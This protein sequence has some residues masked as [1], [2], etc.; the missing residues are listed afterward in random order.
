MGRNP[1]ELLEVVLVNST[2]VYARLR[3]GCRG[4]YLLVGV[5]AVEIQRWRFYGY[6]IVGQL[7]LAERFGCLLITGPD[8]VKVSRQVS[9]RTAPT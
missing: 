5:C 7:Q 6:L 8:S 9:V 3:P 2:M 4:A 1:E